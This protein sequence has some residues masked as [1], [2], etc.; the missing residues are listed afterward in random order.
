M[1]IYPP[2][3]TALKVCLYNVAAV[4]VVL[5]LS[6]KFEIDFLWPLFIVLTFPAA[7]ISYSYTTPTG[8]GFVSFWFLNPLIWGAVAFVIHSAIL[9]R[10]RNDIS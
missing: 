5:L 6:I 9:R 4:L 3:V 8:G 2:L 1:K 10:R 7:L